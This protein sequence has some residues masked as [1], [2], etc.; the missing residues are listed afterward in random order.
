MR[1]FF[2]H[3]AA[4]WLSVLVVALGIAFGILNAAKSDTTVFENV[5]EI[6]VSPVQKLFTNIGH[7][8]SGFFGY[9]SDVDKLKE[10]ISALKN[11]NDELRK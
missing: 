2:K 8:V 6:V 7:G 11:E 4:V 10:E 5:V 3:K 9:F 1:K